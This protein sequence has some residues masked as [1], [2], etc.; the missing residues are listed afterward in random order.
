MSVGY[1]K[2]TSDDFASKSDMRLFCCMC[3]VH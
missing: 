1:V 2:T 3:S